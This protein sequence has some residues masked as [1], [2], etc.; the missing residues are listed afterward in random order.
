MGRFA[1]FISVI[2]SLLLLGSLYVG[3][4][5]SSLL[6]L[7]VTSKYLLWLGLALFLLIQVVTPFLYRSGQI[8]RWGGFNTFMHWLNYLSLGVMSLLV[9]GFAVVDL[10]RLGLWPFK[11]FA[12][13]DPVR[14]SLLTE[15][16]GWGVLA[17]AGVST[18]YGVWNARRGPR[19]REV[20]VPIADL[21]PDLEGFTIVQISDL[22]VG[23]TIHQGYVDSVVAACN[24]LDADIVTVTGDVVDGH[25]PQLRNHVA[26]LGALKSKRGTYFITGNHEYYWGVSEWLSHFSGMG[27]RVL[28]N[29][30]EILTIG[31]AK[32]MIAGV[33]DDQGAS[34]MPEH[35]PDLART[36]R[37]P[38]ATDFKLLLAHRPASCYAAADAGFDL[39][40]SGHTHAGQYIPAAWLVRLFHPY[41]KGLNRHADKLWVYVNTGTGY[42]GPPLRIGTECE[43]T[44]LKLTRA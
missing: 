25:V 24:T 37:S 34:F 2:L 21:H 3:R 9:F 33:P 1:V 40:L 18:L 7:S 20:A 5:I 41:I 36:A 29:A 8:E 38:E 31:R 16:A 19:I 12:A 11:S 43:I 22:H 32:M 13:F 14:R 4:R 26:S 35:V 17:F 23:P 42:W 28:V 10:T 6:S 30:H 15:S 27:M 39:Q 44:R